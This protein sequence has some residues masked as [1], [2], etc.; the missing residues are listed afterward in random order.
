MGHKKKTADKYYYLE[1]Q[2]KSAE[3]AA[4]QLPVIMRT[5]RKV[6][7]VKDKEKE[8]DESPICSEV[9]ETEQHSRTSSTRVKFTNDESLRIEE[10]FQEEIAKKKISLDTVKRK[11]SEDSVLKDL[12]SK[13]FVTKC[14]TCTAFLDQ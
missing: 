9:N 2:I 8:M 13:R 3:R 10:L 12:D 7:Q 5:S 14:D 6:I 1:D 4:E 11:L